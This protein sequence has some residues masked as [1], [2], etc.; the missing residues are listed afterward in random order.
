MELFDLLKKHKMTKE[1][2]QKVR[3]AAQSL[4]H[5]LRDESPKVLVTDWYKDSQ[6]KKQVQSAV[7]SVLHI[8]LPESYDRMLFKQKCDG[9]LGLMTDYAIQGLKWVAE[10]LTVPERFSFGKVGELHIT[11]LFLATPQ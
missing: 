9:V 11:T 7:E 8:H 5:R 6:S 10:R 1:E 3:L 4:L 2:T